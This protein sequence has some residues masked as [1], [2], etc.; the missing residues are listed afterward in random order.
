[1]GGLSAGVGWAFS[2]R[3]LCLREP[4]GCLFTVLQYALQNN[5]MAS[6]GAR[7]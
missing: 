6:E 3:L 1:M 7:D 2:T 5:R 4:V